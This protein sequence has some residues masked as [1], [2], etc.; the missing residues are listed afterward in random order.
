MVKAWH[1]KESCRDAHH[2]REVS[3]SGALTSDAQTVVNLLVCIQKG[4]FG[5]SRI[6]IEKQWANDL[7]REDLTPTHKI[8]PRA[9]AY[10][11]AHS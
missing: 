2:V 11:R 5:D 4:W 1:S 6:Q 7:E 8:E 10:L 3:L 9:Q